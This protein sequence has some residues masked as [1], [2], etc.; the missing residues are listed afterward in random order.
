MAPCVREAKSGFV[1]PQVVP[2][3]GEP[4]PDCESNDTGRSLQARESALSPFFRGSD[5]QDR[6]PASRIAAA[7][8]LHPAIRTACN[9][10]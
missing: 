10:E 5:E 4:V 2:S 7:A 3:E 1:P 9:V 8:M 6:R